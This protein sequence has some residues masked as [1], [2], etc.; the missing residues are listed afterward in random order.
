MSCLSSLHSIII[1]VIII[2]VI[3]LLSPKTVLQNYLTDLLLTYSMECSPS[4]EANRFSAN[5]E[6]SPIL[7]KPNVYYLIDKCPPPVPFL[8][9][10]IPVH[11]IH[12]TSWRYVL[13][14]S[15]PIYGY[16]FQVVSFTNDS[17]QKTCIHLQSTHTC[18]VLHPSNSSRFDYPKYFL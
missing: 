11:A 18:Y 14:L 16:I 15:S 8:S 9:Q 7:W 13:I 4:C 12:H 5:Q 3:L 10:I 6:I 1:I 17:H 2:A